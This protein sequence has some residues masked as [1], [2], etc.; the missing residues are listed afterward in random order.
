M[1]W[2][3][4]IGWFAGILTVILMKKASKSSCIQ[5]GFRYTSLRKPHPEIPPH[6]QNFPLHNTYSPLRFHPLILFE[7]LPTYHTRPV[8]NP[9]GV[10]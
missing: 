4:L 7:I 1:E 10:P 9:P 3:A 2:L 5:M 8:P 6:Y